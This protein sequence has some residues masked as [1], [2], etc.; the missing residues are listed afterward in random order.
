MKNRQARFVFEIL[1]I[2]I[3]WF[4]HISRA[5]NTL[6]L[7]LIIIIMRYLLEPIPSEFIFLSVF[8]F[9]LFSITRIYVDRQSNAIIHNR[10][11]ICNPWRMYWNRIDRIVSCPID[12]VVQ[13]YWCIF[14]WFWH[15][16]HTINLYSEY[17]AAFHD[18]WWQYDK[19]E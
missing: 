11:K 9:E 16:Y 18:Q 5:P 14:S 12:I 1:H 8:C 15:S 4:N 19:T 10:S 7:N 2:C 6:K 3:S 17:P 13:F